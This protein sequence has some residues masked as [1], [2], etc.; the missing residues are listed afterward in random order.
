M[1]KAKIRQTGRP[2]SVLEVED[3]KLVTELA[4]KDYS[5]R[6]IARQFGMC[7]P[8]FNDIRKRQPEVDQAFR[9]G[10]DLERRQLVDDLKKSPRSDAGRIFLLKARHAYYDH[11]NINVGGQQKNPLI[12]HTN[13]VTEEEARDLYRRALLD[14]S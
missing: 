6:E 11:V 7:E 13:P 14:E 9:D 1:R 8:T 2:R 10:R 5:I 3:L 12:V 4:S